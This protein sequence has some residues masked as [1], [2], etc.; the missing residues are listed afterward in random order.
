MQYS[1]DWNQL[2]WNSDEKATAGRRTAIEKALNQAN[3]IYQ[4]LGLTTVSYQDYMQGTP[5]PLI[6]SEKPSHLP[7][8]DD[9]YA[10][11]KTAHGKAL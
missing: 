4:Q 6:P 5:L 7:M 9:E 2:P 3:R 1:I 10:A 8:A 11:L